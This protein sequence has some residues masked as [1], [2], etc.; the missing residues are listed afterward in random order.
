MGQQS[1]FQDLIHSQGSSLTASVGPGNSGGSFLTEEE[2]DDRIKSK[3]S[4]IDEKI[5]Y[6]IEEKEKADIKLRDYGNKLNEA[7]DSY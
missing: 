7:K 3:L 4:E 1:V 6:T 2:E 5:Q